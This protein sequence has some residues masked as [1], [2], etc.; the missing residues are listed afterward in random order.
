[1]HKSF[2]QQFYLFFS[3]E[4]AEQPHSR[5]VVYNCPTSIP[6]SPSKGCGYIG[7]GLSC[8]G[9]S[10]RQTFY[11]AQFPN[12]FRNSFFPGKNFNFN[13]NHF[14]FFKLYFENRLCAIHKS[15]YLSLR[16]IFFE[17]CFILI[18]FLH[19]C[20]LVWFMEFNSTFNNIS[21]ISWRSVL[22]VEEIGV[23]G[24]NHRPTDLPQVTSYA[25]LNKCVYY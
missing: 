4:K 3:E 7:H 9:C 19:K 15:H 12:M 16:C 23:P 2:Y 10:P 22:L 14:I 13:F 17:T 20:G 21:V 25:Y 24:E 11:E 5:P 6:Q 18:H 1:L 8:T